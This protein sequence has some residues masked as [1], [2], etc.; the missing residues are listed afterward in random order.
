MPFYQFTITLKNKTVQQFIR[1]LDLKDL[2]QVW[3]VYEK[4]SV[5]H[6]KSKMAS[7]RVI[8]LSKLDPEVKEFISSQGKKT[9]N[10]LDDLLN[11]PDQK[12]PVSRKKGREGPALES[13]K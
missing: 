2:D 13:R 12:G 4:K 1:Q 11:V 3:R 7:F 5:D 8:Q 9:K 10:E 6:H